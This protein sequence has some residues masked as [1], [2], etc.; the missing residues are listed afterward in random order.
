MTTSSIWL[1][2]MGV[3]ARER[4]LD[5]GGIRTRV[6]EAGDGPT[7]I[8]LSGPGGHV[9]TY[10]RNIAALSRSFSVC[11]VDLVGQGLTARPD[12]DYTL[13]EFADQVEGVLDALDVARAHIAGHAL[14]ALVGHWF[15]VTRPDRI[16]RLVLNTGALARVELP[17]VPEYL[18]PR[19]VAGGSVVT[20]EAIRSRL[21]VLIADPSL[22]S[23]ELVECRYRLYS[24]PGMPETTAKI[25]ANITA[26][27]L[28]NEGERFFE[29]RVMTHLA[30]PTLV[31]WTRHAVTQSWE[32][33]RSVAEAIPNAEFHAIDECGHWPHFERP[34]IV[35]ELMLEFL[36]R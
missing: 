14:G 3:G 10:H 21:E 18:R 6:L 4:F 16:D 22:I 36:S 34:E 28:G 20:R 8:L 31:L 27:V 19:T 26:M 11:A 24:Q 33:G 35:N 9:E 13:D 23:D 12:I 17:Q 2:L 25:V 30:C 7:L 29:P 32:L 1:D 5:A 15:A